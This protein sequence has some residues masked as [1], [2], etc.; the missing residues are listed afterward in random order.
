MVTSGDHG[1]HRLD[2]TMSRT[3]ALGFLL[4]VL[5]CAPA[6]R[7]APPNVVLIVSDDQCWTDFGF[8]GH[9][10][11]KTPNLDKLAAESAVF[12]NGYVPTSL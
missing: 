11:I 8:M 2:R 6:L 4:S 12:P 1:T 3:L 9:E 7:A 10:V 5:P